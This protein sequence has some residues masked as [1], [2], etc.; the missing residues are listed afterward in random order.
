MTFPRPE[1]GETLEKIA[2]DDDTCIYC[3]AC[4]NVCPVDAIIVKRNKIRYEEGQDR[5]WSSTWKDAF[6]KLVTE[7]VER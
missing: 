2:V 5:A 1:V 6:K 7:G 3:E 4:V